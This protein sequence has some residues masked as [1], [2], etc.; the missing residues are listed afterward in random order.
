MHFEPHV[1]V[2]VLSRAID[3]I[4]QLYK[5]WR[6]ERLQFFEDRTKQRISGERPLGHQGGGVVRKE[7][8]SSFG[9]AAREN[10]ERSCLGAELSEKAAWR[11]I[12][13]DHAIFGMIAVRV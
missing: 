11:R 13:N 10:G 1:F 2:L 7:D 5:T 12:T 6:F 9:K 3:A 8:Q 4:S